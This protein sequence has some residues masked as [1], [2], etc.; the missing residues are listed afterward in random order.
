[1]IVLPINVLNSINVLIKHLIINAQLIVICFSNGMI[2]SESNT[3]SWTS[4]PF[5]MNG[6][7]FENMT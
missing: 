1:M 2:S 5:L 7:S 3:P 4:S 6:N